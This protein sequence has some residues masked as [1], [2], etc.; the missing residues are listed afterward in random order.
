MSSRLEYATRGLD[1]DVI[2]GYAGKIIEMIREDARSGVHPYTVRT[3]EQLHQRCDANE[4]LEHAG[5]VYDGSPR[6]IA[7]IRAVQD[8]VEELLMAGAVDGGASYRIVW[9]KPETHQRTVCAS[10]IR[11]RF[12][13]AP[14]T[15]I[16][17]ETLSVQDF[18]GD[19]IDAIAGE[20]DTWH[21]DGDYEIDLVEKSPD[22]ELTAAEV[23]AVGLPDGV[24]RLHHAHPF[25]W[26]SL[27][28]QQ[29][30]ILG[31]LDA[32]VRQPAA[33][34]ALRRHLDRQGKAH[35]PDDVVDLVAHDAAAGLPGFTRVVTEPRG[36]EWAASLISGPD[37]NAKRP[38]YADASR[39]LL[40][41]LAEAIEA[42]PDADPAALI[43][44]VL[45]RN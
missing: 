27:N 31:G 17:C 44:H 38:A 6:S 20:H 5:Q 43:E 15:V 13:L 11:D 9:T 10:E 12:G 23:S 41:R 18:S 4:Y 32:S 39:W 16:T 24:T 22:R 1:Y 14:T 3:F 8:E 42:D 7:E 21:S 36:L 30:E 40:I 45:R 29:R 28:D 34:E 33:E 2:R 26:S 19:A 35:D 25:R 37:G